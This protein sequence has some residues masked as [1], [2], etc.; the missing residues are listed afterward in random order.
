MQ[1]M[2]RLCLPRFHRLLRAVSV[3]VALLASAADAA[4]LPFTGDFRVEIGS[5]VTAFPVSGAATV[6]GSGGGTQIVSLSMGAGQF[7]TTALS[8]SVTA[9]SQ[10]PIRG[11]QLTIANGAAALATTAMGELNGVMPLLGAAKVCLFGT[12]GV[13]VANLSVPLTVIGDGGMVAATGPVNVTVVGAPWTNGTAS[14]QLP[15]FPTIYTRMG[16]AHG[17]ASQAGSTAMPGGSLALVTPIY[18]MTNI[19]AD[20]PVVFG[21]ATLSMHFVPEPSTLALGAGGLALLVAAGRR[22]W[23]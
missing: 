13:A 2:R 16:S 11:L 15:Y 23:L 5:I 12:C 18:V 14:V 4:V 19:A 22:R 20:Q 7:S 1:L 17:P 8:T 3:A 9:P 21:F 6:N 10:F